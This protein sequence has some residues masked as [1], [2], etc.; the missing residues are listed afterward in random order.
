MDFLGRN[1]K[2]YSVKTKTS[3]VGVTGSFWNPDSIKNN[4]KTFDYLLIVILD[5]YYELDIILELSWDEFF[6][7]KRLNKRMNNFNISVTKKLL[8]T[9]KHVY[10]R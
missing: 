9:V 3:R 5:N 6:T 1:G 8:G 4:V 7:H 2:T 10:D